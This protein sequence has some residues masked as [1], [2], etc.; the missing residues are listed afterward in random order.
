ML[1]AFFLGGFFSPVKASA[2]E[3]VGE[4]L[5][6]SQFDNYVV[7]KHYD[8]SYFL[9]VNC[10]VYQNGNDDYGVWLYITSSN[11]CYRKI[12]NSIEEVEN[13][14]NTYSG[15]L[16]DFEDFG[17]SGLSNATLIYSSYDVKYKDS[18]SVF[19]QRT[20]LETGH[21]TVGGLQAPEIATALTSQ[22]VGLVPL[23]LGLLVLAIGLWKGLKYLRQT[24]SRA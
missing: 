21:P 7:A 24:L 2:G 11:R 13:C 23:V 10:D 9:Y 16:D 22:M 5:A 15:N 12:F 19:F 14:L 20:P 3:L 4:N 18:D 17:S 8:G 1:I 6:G